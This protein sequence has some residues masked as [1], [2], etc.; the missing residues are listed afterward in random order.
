MQEIVIAGL[1]LLC[2]GL[3]AAWWRARG[4]AE[5]LSRELAVQQ[6]LSAERD[7]RRAEDRE[8]LERQFRA[9]A[10]DMLAES[11]RQLRCDSGEQLRGVLQPLREQLAGLGRAVAD[12]RADAAARKAQLET[13]IREMMAQTQ[14]IGQD[15]V[16]L[17]RALKGDSKQQGDWGE[18]IL[19]SVLEKSGLVKG[20]HYVTQECVNDAADGRRLYRL[21]VRVLMPQGR[22]VIIDSKVSLTAYADYVAAEDEPTREGALKAHVASVRRHIDEL[23]QKPYARLVSGALDVVLMF[24]PNEASYMLALQREPS[25]LQRAFRQKILLISPTNLIMVL[26]LVYRLWQSEQQHRNVEKIVNVATGLYEKF[27]GFQDT[28]DGVEKN[29]TDALAAYQKAKGQLYTGSGNFL[30]RVESL[31][32]MGVSPKKCLRTEE[33]GE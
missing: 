30:K 33:P 27:A 3:L 18:M 23:A 20:E 19:E 10:A 24:V 32:H 15:A 9:L 13:V 2:A 28:F 7:R 12:T 31:R 17:T 1:A 8:L 25:L 14:Q 11:S 16:N 22:S 4:R 5:R 6:Q 21:D 29:L 26:Q